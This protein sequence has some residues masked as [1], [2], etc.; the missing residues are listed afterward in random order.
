M[1]PEVQQD[2]FKGGS[3]HGEEGITGAEFPLLALMS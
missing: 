3:E 2:V 1:H